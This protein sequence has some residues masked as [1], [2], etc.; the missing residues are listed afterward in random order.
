MKKLLPTLFLLIIGCSGESNKKEIISN[1]ASALTIDRILSKP[2]IAGT[3]PSS[4]NWS[5]D[6]QQLAFL[7]NDS[8]SSRR[9]IW[10]VDSDGSGLRKVTAEDKNAGGVTMFEWTPRL[11]KSYLFTFR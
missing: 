7:W 10:V 4:P 9:A 8:G 3:S 1:Q 2:S 5:S 11:R 6:S